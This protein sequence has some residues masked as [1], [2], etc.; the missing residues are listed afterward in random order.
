MEYKTS[1]WKLEPDGKRLT[2]TDGQGIATV[3]LI[4]KKGKIET[5]RL[6]A[7]PRPESFKQVCLKTQRAY[8]SVKEA[9]ARQTP[10]AV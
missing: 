8:S 1:G 9:L 6:S 7:V 3:R 5:F 4:G 10:V 2:F